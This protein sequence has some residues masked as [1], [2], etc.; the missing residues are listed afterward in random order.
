[1]ETEMNN[2]EFDATA[3]V[4]GDVGQQGEGGEGGGESDDLNDDLTFG[5]A[6]GL[7]D[8]GEEEGDAAT[9]EEEGEEGEQAE[10]PQQG[11]TDAADPRQVEL[12]QRAFELRQRENRLM[13]DQHPDNPVYGADAETVQELD[14]HITPVMQNMA[15]NLVGQ[16]QNYVEGHLLKNLHA[17]LEGPKNPNSPNEP[18]TTADVVRAVGFLLTGGGRDESALHPH[19]RSLLGNLAADVFSV[20]ARAS[21]EAAEHFE[22][23][24]RTGA[25][26]QKAQAALEDA[27]NRDFL[28]RCGAIGVTDKAAIGRL[29]AAFNN[30][31]QTTGA[32]DLKQIREAMEDFF[33]GQKEVLEAYAG[34][35]A[36]QKDQRR[37]LQRNGAASAKGGR[38]GGQASFSQRLERGE[39]TLAEALGQ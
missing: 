3:G 24:G 39:V 1:M 23:R 5:Q 8:T 38:G 4:P 14:A 6:I 10:E 37:A 36:A 33:A 16:Y 18:W 17:L 9:G 22:R 21:V 11:Q 26:S 7:E 29:G 19:Q 31:L 35:K 30:L 20:S 12:D 28:S 25:S 13:R 15:L 34:G 2:S 32:A 27:V